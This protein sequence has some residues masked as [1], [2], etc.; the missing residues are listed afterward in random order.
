MYIKRIN[1]IQMKIQ[2]EYFTFFKSNK[3]FKFK[4]YVCNMSFAQ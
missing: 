2:R 4:F 1:F 3:S